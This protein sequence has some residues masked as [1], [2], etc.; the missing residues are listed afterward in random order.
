LK[1][2]IVEDDSWIAD[3][4]RQVLLSLNPQAS[5]TVFERVTPALNHFRGAWVDLLLTDLHLPDASGLD[6]VTAMKRL[7]PGC[8]CILVTASIDRE[9]VI[10]ARKAGITDFIAKPFNVADLLKRL[11]TLIKTDTIPLA[12]LEGLND[13]SA[14]LE[15]RLNQTLFIPW[16]QPGTRQRAETLENACSVQELVRLARQEPAL[17]AGLISAVNRADRPENAFDCLSVESAIEQLGLPASIALCQRLA[18]SRPVLSDP[19]L[20]EL[21]TDL[22]A[23]QAKLAKILTRLADHQSIAQ[24]PVR[25]AVSLCRLG[26][27]AVLCALQNFLNFGQALDDEQLAPAIERFAPAFG[28]RIKVNLQLPFVIRE[29]VGSLFKLPQGGQRKD[30]VLMRIAALECGLD[31]NP[32][33]LAQLKQWIGLGS[34]DLSS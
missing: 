24:G 9:T 6:V 30:L 10:K 1:I 14:F 23:E 34:Q 21:A 17:T 28:N 2:V 25:T 33:Q 29:L 4:L 19:R 16:S 5:I 22:L 18:R 31:N 15:Q 8:P 7:N 32:A 13:L 3:L 26:E 20:Q 11:G 12:D 27:M